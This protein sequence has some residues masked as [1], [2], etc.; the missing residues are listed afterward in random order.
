MASPRASKTFLH[1]APMARG[2]AGDLSF[3]VASWVSH[4]HGQRGMSLNAGLRC[5]CSFQVS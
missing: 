4:M 3:Q 1:D 5:V 2:V